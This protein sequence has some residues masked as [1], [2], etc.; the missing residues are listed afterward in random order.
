MDPFSVAVQVDSVFEVHL[1]VGVNDFASYDVRSFVHGR[2]DAC[3]TLGF[4]W[5]VCTGSLLELVR[6][7]HGLM[8]LD[9]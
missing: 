4:G 5:Y 3:G 2:S 6:T 7:V 9:E 1:I 8:V